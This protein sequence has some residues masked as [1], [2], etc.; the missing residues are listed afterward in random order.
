MRISRRVGRARGETGS[1]AGDDDGLVQRDQ[2]GITILP[3]TDG[4][5]VRLPT[6]A[7]NVDQSAFSPRAPTINRIE[8]N[9]IDGIR[10]T[11]LMS[12]AQYPLTRL[13]NPL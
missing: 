8:S 4:R 10:Y 9:R 11:D 2:R 7:R 12:K 3:I 13:A 1:P 6:P 5:L